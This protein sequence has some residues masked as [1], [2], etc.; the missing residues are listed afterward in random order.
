MQQR[1]GKA[2]QYDADARGRKPTWTRVPAAARPHGLSPSRR[3]GTLLGGPAGITVTRPT[4]TDG[5]TETSMPFVSR[6]ILRI[7]GL[8]DTNFLARVAAAEELTTGTRAA[9]D[10]VQYDFDRD[11]AGCCAAMTIVVAIRSSS[12]P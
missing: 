11:A 1:A 7:K 6:S 4:G 8:N 2:A 5:E 12:I 3:S 9:S 10:S